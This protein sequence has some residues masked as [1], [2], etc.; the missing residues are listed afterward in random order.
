METTTAYVYNVNT[1][2]VKQVVTGEYSQIIDHFQEN[3]DSEEW[4]LT[5]SPAF[6]FADGLIMVEEAEEIVL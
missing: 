4:G 5:S 2:E 1:M 3:F 6:G